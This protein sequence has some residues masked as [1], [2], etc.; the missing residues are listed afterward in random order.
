MQPA[1]IDKAHCTALTYSHKGLRRDFGTE[2]LDQTDR[3]QPGQ[4]TTT[5]QQIGIKKIDGHVVENGSFPTSPVRIYLAMGEDMGNY[6]GAGAFG[7]NLH[8]NWYWLVSTKYE[9]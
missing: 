9:Q 1:H 2:W 8:E 6:Y 3:Y 4:F 5:I 7:L